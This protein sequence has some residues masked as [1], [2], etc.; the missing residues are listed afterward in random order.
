M[1]ATLKG[2]HQEQPF[3]CSYPLN[4]GWR[5]AGGCSNLKCKHLTE[6]ARAEFFAKKQFPGVD[7]DKAHK[8]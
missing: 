6:E 8:K 2:K 4:C 1:A 3:D 7:I 5:S